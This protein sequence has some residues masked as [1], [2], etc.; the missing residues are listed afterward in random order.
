MFIRNRRAFSLR[1]CSRVARRGAWEGT[2]RVATQTGWRCLGGCAFPALLLPCPQ[3][4]L[5]QHKP[6]PTNAAARGP[7]TYKPSC[8]PAPLP[9]LG[10]NLRAGRAQQVGDQL[11]LVHHVAP[12]EQRLACTNGSA[13]GAVRLCHSLSHDMPYTALEP[14]LSLLSPSTPTT[15]PPTPAA[16]QRSAAHPAG[17]PQRCSRWTRCRWRASTWRRRSHTARGRGT[18]AWPHSQSRT[19]SAARRG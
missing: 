5:A 14:L 6:A 13:L 19:P 18:S 16:G 8:Y 12:R 7:G 1:T 17:S 10:D 15:S 2:P 11:Q 3:A 9:C 4:H